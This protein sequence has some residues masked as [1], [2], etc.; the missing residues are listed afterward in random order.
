[1]ITQMAS[2]VWVCP[3]APVSLLVGDTHPETCAHPS[4]SHGTSAEKPTEY[5]WIANFHLGSICWSY[6]KFLIYISYLVSFHSMCDSGKWQCSENNCPTR[7]LIEG[8]FVRTFDGKQYALPGK[9]TYVAS[10]VNIIPT[11]PLYNINQCCLFYHTH[12]FVFIIIIL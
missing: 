1:M 9:C 11:T 3:A 6:L 10:Q 7:C 4:V 8:Q 5:P 2:A 12:C